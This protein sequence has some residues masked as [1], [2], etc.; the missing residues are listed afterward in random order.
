MNIDRMMLR[1]DLGRA[2]D[3]GVFLN[4]HYCAMQ[5]L[6]QDWREEDR[7]DFSLM[8]R[9]LQNDLHVLGLTATSLP[10]TTRA[11]LTVNGRLGAAYV[12]RGSRLGAAFLRKRVPAGM[13]ASY[14]DYRPVLTWPQFLLQLDAVSLV[15]GWHAGDEVV[16]GAQA[17]FG[18]FSARL[19]AAMAVAS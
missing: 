4:M 17:M 7:D 16:R 2:D 11:P 19:T 6:K 10:A 18:I 9:C 14:L 15:P 3:Y 1:F 5:D 8:M 12:V 13:V